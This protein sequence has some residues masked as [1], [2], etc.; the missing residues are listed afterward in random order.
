M[1]FICLR[2][3]KHFQFLL[4]IFQPLLLLNQVNNTWASSVIL[5]NIRLQG[6]IVCLDDQQIVEAK[7]CNDKAKAYPAI[8]E[9]FL[10]VTNHSCKHKHH[11]CCWRKEELIDH[12]EFVHV[13]VLV[14]FYKS[15]VNGDKQVRTQNA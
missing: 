13:F 9:L 2:D 6:L 15:L 12:V 7:L 11:E 1:L 3:F 10:G 14:R 8:L 4:K 5:D